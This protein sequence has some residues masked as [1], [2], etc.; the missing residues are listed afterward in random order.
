MSMDKSCRILN[1]I[2]TLIKIRHRTLCRNNIITKIHSI[3]IV[4]I[5]LPLVYLFPSWVAQSECGPNF[6]VLIGSKVQAHN[7]TQTVATLSLYPQLA[8]AAGCRQLIGN[9]KEW[10]IWNNCILVHS[11]DNLSST[12]KAL[13]TTIKKILVHKS[14]WCLPMRQ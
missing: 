11:Y 3:S 10:C 9:V 5:L 7:K 8:V 6:L 14:V 13:Y 12:S 4:E 1:S 2:L